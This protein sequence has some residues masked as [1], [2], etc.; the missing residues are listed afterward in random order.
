MRCAVWYHL[1]NLKNVKNTHGGVLLLVKLQAKRLKRITYL[2][3]FESNDGILI[4][5]G[6]R[7]TC[8]FSGSVTTISRLMKLSVM[9][10]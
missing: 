10:S 8:Y 9:F 6:K 4:N 5:L 3:F 7:M 2:F 1:Y